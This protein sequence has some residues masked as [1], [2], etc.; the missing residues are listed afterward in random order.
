MNNLTVLVAFLGSSLHIKKKQVYSW[1]K[2]MLD[3]NC[4]VHRLFLLR[5]LAYRPLKNCM[6]IICTIFLMVNAKDIRCK[7]TPRQTI[8]HDRKTL[9][10]SKFKAAHCKPISN[11]MKL[12]RGTCPDPLHHTLNQS[13]HVCFD[14]VRMFVGCPHQRKNLTLTLKDK[15]SDMLHQYGLSQFK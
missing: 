12:F 8:I 10:V 13:P 3:T 2:Y 6:Y 7:E 15:K 11:Y 9:S 14:T 4:D 1:Y 5:C